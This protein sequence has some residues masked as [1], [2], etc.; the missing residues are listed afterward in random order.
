ME[1]NNQQQQQEENVETVAKAEYD[2]LVAERDELLQYKPKE[3]TDEEVK[4]QQ[5]REAFEKEKLE[6]AIEKAGLSDFAEFISSQDEIEAFQGLVKKI[7][8]NVKK[9]LAYKPENHKQ[10][11]EYSQFAQKGDTKGMIGTKLANL[12]K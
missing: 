11:D 2:A 7:E 6:F 1:E 10:T 4:A 9:A 3:L 12:F 8:D 5:D